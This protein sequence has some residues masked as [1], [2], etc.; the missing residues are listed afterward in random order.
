MKAPT[1]DRDIFCHLCGTMIFSIRHKY[2]KFTA[3]CDKC[4]QSLERQEV[5][6]VKRLNRE[7]EKMRD[8]NHFKH[9]SE[10]YN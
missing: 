1:D 8:S 3:L 5:E 10:N 2:A 6:Q 9:S 4:L 7:I